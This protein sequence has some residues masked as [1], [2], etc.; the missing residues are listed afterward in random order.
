VRATTS[1]SFTWRR[2]PTQIRKIEE[3]SFDEVGLKERCDLRRLLRAQIDVIAPGVLVIDE[4]FCEWEDSKRSIDLL[5]LD[6]DAQL[7][8]IELKR[9]ENG[10]HMELQAVR[11]AAMRRE[12]GRMC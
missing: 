11:Y 12:R 6:N 1:R 3:T 7:V 8:A 4:E 10:G 5:A 9:T 2:G